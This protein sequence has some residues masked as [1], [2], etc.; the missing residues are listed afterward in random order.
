ME[1]LEKSGYIVSVDDNSVEAERLQTF[2]IGLNVVSERRRLTLTQSIYIEHRHKV[3][4]LVGAGE[5]WKLYSRY[6]T[7]VMMNFRNIQLSWD[8]NQ[9]DILLKLHFYIDISCFAKILLKIDDIFFPYILSK[10]IE[11]RE[12]K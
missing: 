1:R 3:V 4:E 6:N 11:I 9:L 5:C 10:V 2:L 12:N 7:I 8:C